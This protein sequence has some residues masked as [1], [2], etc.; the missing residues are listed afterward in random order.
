MSKAKRLVAGALLGII[1][2]FAITIVSLFMMPFLIHNL[3]DRMYGLWLLFGS[4]FGFYGLLDL[5]L[6]GAVGRYMSRAIGTKDYEEV[7][8]VFNSSLVVFSLIGCVALLISIGISCFGHVFLKDPV[9][10]ELF[11]KIILMTGFGLA[12]SFPMRSFWALFASH[13]RYDLSIYIDLVK[14]AVRTGLI[15]FFLSR[16]YGLL[17]FAAIMFVTDVG[18]YVAN[19]FVSLKVAPYIEFSKKHVHLSHIR[20]LFGYSVYSFISK[21]AGNIKF[22]IDNF[23]IAGFLGLGSVTVYSIASRLINYYMQ[24]LSNTVGILTP[25]FSQYEGQNNFDAIREKLFFMTKISGYIACLIGSLMIIFGKV[26]IQRWVGVEYLQAYKIMLILLVP[27]LLALI[28]SPSGQVLYGI[29][30]HKFLAVVNVVEAVCNLILSLI[31]VQRY[32][33]FG[34]ALGTAIPLFI[35]TVFIKPVYV[36]KVLKISLWKYVGEIFKVLCVSLI[37]CVGLATVLNR[38]IM[39]KYLMIFALGVIFTLVYGGI[40]FFVGFS[41]DE[42]LI[43]LKLLPKKVFNN[44]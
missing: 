1:N 30:K 21:I 35:V 36:C 22:N 42:R 11:R 13:L 2:F 15:V 29:S 26:F 18:G 25:V 40:I 44:G 23:V 8:K 28:Q 3:G 12:V 7:N 43:F 14:L 19:F 34:V 20:K 32:G 27:I 39:P 9:E 41:K 17:T 31:L 38:F 4:F 24:F 5:G 6:G 33:L 16:G 10:A 37:V